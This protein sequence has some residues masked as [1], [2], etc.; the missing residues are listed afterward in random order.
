MATDP[1]PHLPFPTCADCVRIGLYI[2][3][4]L[5]D[6]ERDLGHD[7]LKAFLLA[8]GGRQLS[9]RQAAPDVTATDPFGRAE[10]WLRKA[11]G[12]GKIT[13]PKGPAGRAAR[14]AW[15]TYRML[16]DGRSLTQIAR[17]TDCHMRSVSNRKKQFA[18]L[19]LLP[20]APN[21][22][23]PHQEMTNC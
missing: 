19:G 15:T 18:A 23:S 7:V 14:I 11:V 20:A 6:M 2:P 22:T 12:F 8:H 1:N 17:A 9:L 10:A 13:V 3:P 16:C 21:P 5:R 4:F